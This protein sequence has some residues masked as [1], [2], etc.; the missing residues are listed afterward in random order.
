[1]KVKPL[2]CGCL[3]H[4]ATCNKHAVTIPPLNDLQRRRHEILIREMDILRAQLA[5]ERRAAFSTV[6]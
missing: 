4:V 3:T 2:P 1:M 5:E 6:E